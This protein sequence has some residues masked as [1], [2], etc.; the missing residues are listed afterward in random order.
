L[1]GY[2]A[3]QRLSIQFPEAQFYNLSKGVMHLFKV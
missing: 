2:I 3:I 1:N